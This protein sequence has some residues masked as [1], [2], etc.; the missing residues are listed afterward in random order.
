MKPARRPANGS[1]SLGTDRNSPALP[2]ADLIDSAPYVTLSNLL[3][4][5]LAADA[6]SLH[7]LS[8]RWAL[9][10]VSLRDRPY[11]QDS[12]EVRLL[13]AAAQR[14]CQLDHQLEFARQLGRHRGLGERE[15]G[16][17]QKPGERRFEVVFQVRGR[18]A[19]GERLLLFAAGEGG[20]DLATQARATH[21]GEVDLERDGEAGVF[22]DQLG[23]R[24]I[25]LGD[26]VVDDHRGVV[27]AAQRAEAELA[28]GGDL[29]RDAQR[30][31]QARGAAVGAGYR[32]NH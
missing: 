27:A 31:G 3:K 7:P 11:L 9:R 17:E 18:G 14:A 30:G 19:H 15:F 29:D 1:A 22:P 26:R 16:V 28:A 2:A 20:T 23:A 13:E 25:G 24:R 32:G 4:R 12:L 6:A 5:A 21:Q 8:R 10:L